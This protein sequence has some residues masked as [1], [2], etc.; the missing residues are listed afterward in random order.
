VRTNG[1]P[2]GTERD[3]AGIR[4][5]EDTAPAWTDETAW[6]VNDEPTLDI[7]RA[8]GEPS[9]LLRRIRQSLRLRDGRIAVTSLRS[10]DIR[11]F[12]PAAVHLRTIARRSS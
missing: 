6:R 9:Y 3:S 11:I 8:E 4:I 12:D 5:V 10:N 1:R 2:G 7:G